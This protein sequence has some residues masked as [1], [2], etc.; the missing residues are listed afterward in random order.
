MSSLDEELQSLQKPIPNGT[1]LE[2]LTSGCTFYQSDTVNPNAQAADLM[3]QLIFNR[4]V[5]KRASQSLMPEERAVGQTVIAHINS[6]LQGADLD[7]A[8]LSMFGR[9][10]FQRHASFIQDVK[11]IAAS[12]TQLPS[13]LQ[14]NVGVNLSVPSNGQSDREILRK[15]ATDM[16]SGALESYRS[17]DAPMEDGS[18]QIGSS[19]MSVD[20]VKTSKDQSVQLSEGALDQITLAAKALVASQDDIGF[21]EQQD[22]DSANM[23]AT[24]DVTML[25]HTQE[26]DLLASGSEEL[27]MAFSNDPISLGDGGFGLSAEDALIGCDQDLASIAGIP[28]QALMEGGDFNFYD[29]AKC[30]EDGKTEEE[31]EIDLE[32]KTKDEDLKIGMTNEFEIEI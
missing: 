17:S 4:V 19:E 26:T 16:S 10:V 12:N 8:L 11:Q 30:P 24:S 22:R 9:E 2:W 29:E 23:I 31:I 25:Q 15:H 21:T 27:D 13:D 1:D 3:S 32:E 5:T 7:N 18:I 28:P 6:G 14:P 20:I